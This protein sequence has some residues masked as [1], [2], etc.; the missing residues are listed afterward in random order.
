[1]IQQFSS[2][3]LLSLVTVISNGSF[4]RNYS[5]VLSNQQVQIDSF[6]LELLGDSST[7][8]KI[9]FWE[10]V[11]G[12][13]GLD[14]GRS[15]S[16]EV[17]FVLELE[18]IFP[19]A[20]SL[21]KSGKSKQKTGVKT[22]AVGKSKKADQLETSSVSKDEV[23]ETELDYADSSIIG[24]R[25]L[26]W[27]HVLRAKP[28]SLKNY[29]AIQASVFENKGVSAKLAKPNDA[30][31][32]TVSAISKQEELADESVI[33]DSSTEKQIDF[34]TDS[35]SSKEKLTDQLQKDD[36]KDEQKSENL[37][38]KQASESNETRSSTQEKQSES[39]SS[40]KENAAKIQE[41]YD[42]T[43]DNPTSQATN[44]LQPSDATATD[45]LGDNLKHTSEAVSTPDEKSGNLQ[46]QK[47]F[48]ET[49]KSDKAIEL[50][51]KQSLLET[52]KSD[53]ATKENRESDQQLFKD[54]EGHLLVDN[55][56]LVLI[57]PFLKH[58]F[59][60]IG[61]LDENNKIT[62]KV[63]ATHVLHYVATGNE[64][65][66][67]QTML[68]EKYLVGLDPFESIPREITISETIKLE[69]E[70]LMMAVRENWK[71][72][73]SSSVEAVRETFIQRQGKL[74]NES[75]NPRLVV[76]RKTVDILLNQLNWTISIIRLP[77]LD[78][79]IF[80]EW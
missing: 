26:E 42:L 71:P 33:G 36:Q 60:G 27:I 63:L 15:F 44:Q 22:K 1:L 72:M 43:P 14:A 34:E 79:I 75:P 65:D 18:A 39:I 64:C 2:D 40:E 37:S 76:E 17:A 8:T 52:D 73:K 78:E 68:L 38:E 16:S 66:F 9:R 80:V 45:D 77:W 23:S 62:D 48:S 41:T 3:F 19:K 74:I 5:S 24:I 55:A 4:E 6:I 56:G 69:V 13:I 12:M 51:D 46:D 32:A 21:L 58:F 20:I 53:K 50:Q 54:Q 30:K 67:E 61:L 25:L 35:L 31:Q 10:A 49:N 29:S 57:H 70:N 47:L 59:N 28:I 7:Q 11:F